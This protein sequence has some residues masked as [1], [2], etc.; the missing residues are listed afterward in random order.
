MH[1]PQ[2]KQV[3]IDVKGDEAEY[4]S[5]QQDG[6]GERTQ[7]YTRAFHGQDFFLSGKIPQ[8]H[9]GTHQGGEGKRERQDGRE[10]T[11]YQPKYI[12]QRYSVGKNP[13]RQK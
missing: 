9:K 8:C 13:F 1:R 11:E 7:G 2:G 10:S 4:D 6:T 5:H 12:P 3:I